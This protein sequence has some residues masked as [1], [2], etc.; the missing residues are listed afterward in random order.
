MD[1]E[2]KILRFNLILCDICYFN[3]F[4]YVKFLVRN[5]VL[6]ISCYFYNIKQDIVKLEPNGKRE[7]ICILRE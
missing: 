7:L 4:V 2:N 1:I 3:N 6:F 5:R